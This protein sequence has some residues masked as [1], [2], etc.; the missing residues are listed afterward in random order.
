MSQKINNKFFFRALPPQKRPPSG[1]PPLTRNASFFR[2]SD[3]PRSASQRTGSISGGRARHR[4]SPAAGATG[5]A[6]A[7]P[8]RPGRQPKRRFLRD[9][10]PKRVKGREMTS[11]GC[12]RLE[13]WHSEASVNSVKTRRTQREPQ[14]RVGGRFPSVIALFAAITTSA[15]TTFPRRTAL[16]LLREDLTTR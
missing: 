12:L 10:R 1:Q 4:L 7:S 15:L 9:D 14:G 16:L 6:S 2:S 13:K 3:F 5:G 11:V 8:G